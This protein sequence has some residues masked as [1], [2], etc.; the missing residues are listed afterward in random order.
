MKKLLKAF[1]RL[2]IVDPKNMSDHAYNTG[3]IDLLSATG[4]GW[5]EITEAQ[6]I[7]YWE[8][9]KRADKAAALH[10]ASCRQV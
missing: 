10:D 4:V 9:H 5:G 3:M 8:E 6:D 7:A 1:Q 2:W